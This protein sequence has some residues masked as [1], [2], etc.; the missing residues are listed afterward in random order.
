MKRLCSVCVRKDSK[1]VPNKN[2]RPLLGKPLLIHSLDHARQSGLFD[3]IV[4]SSDSHII[5]RMAKDWGVNHTIDRPKSLAS[6]TANKLPVIQHSFRIAETLTGSTFD[7]I[8]DLDA[9]SPLRNQE[10]LKGAVRLLESREE[11]AN[12]ITGAPARRSPYFNLVELDESGVAH[13]SGK[14]HSI[15]KTIIRRQDA[16]PC[17]DLNASIY[18]W[19]R[20]SLLNASSVI[21]SDTHLY[22]MP[23][24]RSIDI[25]SE[26]DF[27]WV[28]FLMKYR[29]NIKQI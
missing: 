5:L 6:D 1:G 9:T 14:S 18:V 8:V 11:I 29:N 16:P 22:V 19:R 15:N 21:Q 26:L 2:I 25:D 20:N 13:L 27:L 24:E 4:V 28:E 23:E 7:T 17:F 3:S 12:V 10:D